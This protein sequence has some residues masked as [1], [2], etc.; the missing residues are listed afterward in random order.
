MP[1]VLII[2]DSELVRNFHSYILKSEKFEVVTANDGVDGLEKFF[3][4]K[5]DLVIVDINMPK[6]DG[7]ELVKQ[8]RASEDDIETPIIMISTEDSE[9]K[10]EKGF[11]AGANVYIVKPTEPEKLVAN[12]RTLIGK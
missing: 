11:D 7:Y 2:D 6:M 8:I 3:C 12:I 9:N 1:R 10:K 5:F 4:A